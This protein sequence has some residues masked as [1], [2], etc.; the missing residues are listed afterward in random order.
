[1]TRC[2]PPCQ[3]LASDPCAAEYDDRSGDAPFQQHERIM[4]RTQRA[5]HMIVDIRPVGCRPQHERLAVSEQQFRQSPDG[6]VVR[7]SRECD[8]LFRLDGID[9]IAQT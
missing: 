4:F 9:S 1:M 2:D 6:G 5:T 3:T 7:G 8:R